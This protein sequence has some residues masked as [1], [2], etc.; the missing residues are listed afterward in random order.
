VEGSTAEKTT[1]KKNRAKRDAS[2]L[3]KNGISAGKGVKKKKAPQNE[4]NSEAIA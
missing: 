3:K 4:E 1:E 2:T